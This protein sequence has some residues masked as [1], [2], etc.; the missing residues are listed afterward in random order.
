MQNTSSSSHQWPVLV[1]RHLFQVTLTFCLWLSLVGRTGAQTFTTLHSFTNVSSFTATNT[2][3]ANPYAGLTLS[4]HELYGTTYAGGDSTL[5]TLFSVKTDGTGFTKL[6]AF[7]NLGNIP[8]N[9]AALIVS[10]NTLYGTTAFGGTVGYGT[11]FA[12]NTDG[13]GFTNL[14]NFN[15]DDGYSPMA[16]LVLSGNR[17]YGT[18]E[19]GGSSRQGN[20]F[21]LNTDG[22]GFTNLYSFSAT[23]P[24]T[25]HGGT[26]ADGALPLSK[27]VLSGSTLYGTAANGGVW[28]WGAVFAINTNGSGFTNLHSFTDSEGRWPQAGLVLSGGTLYG[29]TSIGGNASKGTVFAVNTAGTVFTN[30]HSFMAVVSNTNSDGANPYAALTLSGDTLYGTTRFGGGSGNG[31]VFALKIDGTGFTTVHSFGGLTAF[32]GTYTNSDGSNPYDELALGSNMVYGTAYQGGSAGNGTVFS[33]SVMPVSAPPLAILPSGS[34][35]VLTWPANWSGFTLE[36]ASNLGAPVVWHS[37]LS[38]PVIFN[39]QNTVTNAISGS[40]RFYRLRE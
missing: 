14:Y 30:L 40:Q 39:G 10:G 33:L 38:A 18:T 9:R 8:G 24:L 6:L 25:G 26:N 32:S 20:V 28:G 7:S 12:I 17:L 3:G 2:D 27:L 29:T 15:G 13:S 35:V 11:V 36:V 22:S 23:H 31:T 37:N 1:W 4:G 5:G 19:L 34:N 16:G 21:A